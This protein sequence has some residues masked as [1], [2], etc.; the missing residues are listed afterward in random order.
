V[1]LRLGQLRILDRRRHR[2]PGSLPRVDRRQRRRR[3]RP[4]ASLG[5]PV[6]AGSLFPYAL[7]LSVFLQVFVL[8][9]VGAIADRSAHKKQL[10]ALFA[11][12]GS[13]ATAGLVFLTGDRY[14]LGGLPLFRVPGY[15]PYQVQNNYP[16]TAVD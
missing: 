7:S 12:L 15:L 3:L 8:P 14:L 1:L 11:Y 10:L 4:G 6:T 16:M 13:A 9:T 5:I 2:L